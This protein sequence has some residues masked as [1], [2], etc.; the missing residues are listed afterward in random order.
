[1]CL[2]PDLHYKLIMNQKPQ[3]KG[4]TEAPQCLLGSYLCPQQS[5]NPQLLI[6]IWHANSEGL[7]MRDLKRCH[8]L[9]S[10]VTMPTN[11]AGAALRAQGLRTEQL[12]Q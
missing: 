1:M 9:H 3:K 6:S 5:P 8:F 4:K 12:G 2:F 11:A 10:W 7:V